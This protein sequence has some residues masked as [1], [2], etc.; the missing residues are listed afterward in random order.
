VRD[1]FPQEEKEEETD[2]ALFLP[3]SFDDE[4]ELQ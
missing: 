1:S 2:G 4:G 3:V